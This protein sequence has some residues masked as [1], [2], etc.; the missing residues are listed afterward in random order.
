MKVKGILGALAFA[1]LALLPRA[2][3]AQGDSSARVVAPGVTLRRV[4]RPEGPW[5]IHALAVD[6]GNRE[7][8]VQAE[9][10]CDRL[11]GRERPSAI[12]KR[13]NASGMEVLAAINAGFFDLEGGSGATVG[14]VVVEG[15]I[16]QASGATNGAA[17][18]RRPVRSQLAIERDGR[19]VIARFTLS[20]T[21]RTPR[22][23]WPIAALN[24][25]PAADAVT[26]YTDWSQ[27]PPRVPATMRAVSVP[28]ALESRSGDTLRYRVVA[29]GPDTARAT[30]ERGLLV[31]TGAAAAKVAALRPADRVTAVATL[32]PDGTPRALVTGW[33]AIV[34]DG[35]SLM[36]TL[37]SLEGASTAFATTRHPRS[38]VG[39]SRGGD[40]LLLVAVDG[41]QAA[42]VGMSLAE[43]ARTMLGL[44][45]WNAL[46][47]DGGGSTALVVRDSVVNTPSDPTGER[48]VG[49]VLLVTR[50]AAAR[51]TR[52]LPAPANVPGCVLAGA[53]D[54]D[55]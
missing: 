7:L 39:I 24:E 29:D 43:L 2:A 32:T 21:V 13:L 19:P 11:T 44:G 31:G 46:N 38:A 50:P 18:R 45:A 28:L 41:R 54:P 51:P 6:L 14:N 34:R 37:D 16:A 10:A 33:P 12:S 30:S 1:A 35:R 47:L 9:R 42:S 55:R 23:R 26:L 49:D 20:G 22:G 15:E 4:V 27:R 8:A 53:R 25:P 48:A 5:V 40:T 36:E 52:S 17:P 3:A